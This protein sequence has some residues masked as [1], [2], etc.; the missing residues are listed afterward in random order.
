[1]FGI[2]N[3]CQ[4]D[5]MMLC[6]SCDVTD[7]VPQHR[8]LTMY[9]ATWCPH[10]ERQKKEF[11]GSDINVSYVWCD[12]GGICPTFVQSYPTIVFA[13]GRML[14]G[15]TTAEVIESHF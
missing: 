7:E 10:C 2:E 4:R 14:H 3:I 11:E 15:F 6:C 8:S 12:K 13:D 1:M 5:K 9:G